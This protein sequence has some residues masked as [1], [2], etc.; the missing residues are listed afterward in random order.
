MLSIF[1]SLNDLSASAEVLVLVNGPDTESLEVLKSFPQVK[2]LNLP[3]HQHPGS[4]RNQLIRESQGQ[5]LVFLDDDLTVPKDYFSALLKLINQKPEVSVYGGPNWTPVVSN[6]FQVLQGK[7]LSDSWL[8]GPVSRRYELLRPA[9]VGEESLILCNLTVK[10]QLA[11]QNLFRSDLFCAEENEWLD[12]LKKLGAVFLAS[13]ELGVSHERR[14]DYISFLKQIKKYGFGRGQI[15]KHTEVSWNHWF[16]SLTVLLLGIFCWVR[17]TF[18]VWTLGFYWGFWFFK[19]FLSLSRYSTKEK[20]T[21]LLLFP[22]VQLVYALAVLRGFQYSVFS[23][24]N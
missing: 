10:A 15:L 3:E 8:V 6:N 17:P 2:V 13:P 4:A 24:K 18:V 14:A 5:Y 21:T 9:Q 22:G 16:P 12:R 19:S 1:A 11:K 20:M 7:W 23:R